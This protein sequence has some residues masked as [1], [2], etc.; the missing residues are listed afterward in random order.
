VTS[1][2]RKLF[3]TCYGTFGLKGA[4]SQLLDRAREIALGSGRA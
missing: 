1:A 4:D 3:F 2:G